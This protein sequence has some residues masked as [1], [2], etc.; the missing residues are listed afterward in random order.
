MVTGEDNSVHGLIPVVVSVNTALPE[1]VDGG[2][3][4]ADKVLALGEKEPPA[5]V[6]QVPPV[7]APPIVPIKTA[8]PPWQII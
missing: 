5:V 6:D 8:D 7:A 1:K 4:V 3:Q 2:V